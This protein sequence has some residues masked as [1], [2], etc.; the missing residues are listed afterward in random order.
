MTKI[1]WGAFEG[2]SNLVSVT[3]PENMTTIENDVFRDC[4]SL[5]SIAIPESVTT[6]GSGVFYGCSSLLDI[7]IPN[8]VTKIDDWTFIGCSSLTSVTIPNSVTEIGDYAFQDCYGLTSIYCLAK[9]PPSIKGT[10]FKEV[11]K[12]FTD[13]YVPAGTIDNYKE[14]EGWKA[15]E[16]IMELE[17]DGI[18]SI[19]N[20]CSDDLR[21]RYYFADAERTIHNEADAIYDLSGRR[22]VN[23]KRGLYIQG[24]K[25]IIKQ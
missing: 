20:S 9:T 2:C 24:N 21:K 14:T 4:S 8:G 5:L 18:E 12:S 13:L 7:N 22:M 11:D 19:H 1:G 17:A 23:P 25:K 16:N 10:T 3:L 6:I 15:F